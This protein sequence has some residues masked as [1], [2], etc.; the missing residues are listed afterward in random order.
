MTSR[1]VPVFCAVA[2]VAG[3]TDDD[4]FITPVLDAS[5]DAVQATDGGLDPNCYEPGQGWPKNLECSGLY[6]DW[7]NK[8]VAPGVREFAPAVAL[9]SDGAGKTRWIQFPAGAKIDNS[10]PAEWKF[11]VGTRAWKE[12]RHNGKRVETRLWV[13]R[14][15]TWWDKVTY[16][17]TD[18]ETKTRQANSN[19][20]VVK[21]EDGSDYVIPS[22]TECDECHGGRIDKLLG[23]EGPLLGLPGAQG[24]TLT[25]LVQEGLLT[26]PPAK[27]TYEMPDDGTGLAKAILPWIHV[28]CGI[29]CHNEN[30]NTEANHTGLFMRFH[31]TELEGKPLPEW[32]VIKNTVHAD[33][34]LPAFA[35]WKRIDP[36]YPE[37]SLLYHLASQRKA[38]GDPV[39]MPTI[40]TRIVDHEHIPMLKEWIIARGKLEPQ[41]PVPTPDAGAPVPVA[42]AGG[43]APVVD[44][45]PIAQP[46]D[47]AVVDAALP[48]VDAGAPPVDVDAGGPPVEV[49]AGGPPPVDVDAAAPGTTDPTAPD[50]DAAAPVETDAATP[51]PTLPPV[52]P[53][54]MAAPVTPETTTP[55]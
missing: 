14:E 48:E 32:N 53:P 50:L 44:A 40:A 1:F 54:E 23:F 49:D 5:P 28:N 34:R 11:P 26:H 3:C 4:P 39:Q 10:N 46:E 13:K 31:Q 33:T 16:A 9:W 8:T 45:G 12:F 6:S 22:R 19:G 47:A 18:N 17:W 7:T 29:S 21:F 41:Q 25:T 30:T 51:D 20:E 24:I 38:K 27:T 43:P 37:D 52:T 36:G 2:V 15:E 55:V 42:D 35:G